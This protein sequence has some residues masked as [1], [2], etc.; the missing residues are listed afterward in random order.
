MQ[1]YKMVKINTPFIEIYFL[2][3]AWYPITNIVDTLNNAEC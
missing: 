2:F 1:R 3:C